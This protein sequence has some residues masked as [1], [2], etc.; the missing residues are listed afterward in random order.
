MPRRSAQ[1]IAADR[2]A[3]VIQRSENPLLY[4]AQWREVQ[5]MAFADRHRQRETRV[6]C[7]ARHVR[8]GT[9]VHY[10]VPGQSARAA[11]WTVQGEE[12]LHLSAAVSA[13]FCAFSEALHSAAP[14]ELNLIPKTLLDP[15]GAR[16]RFVHQG[17]VFFLRVT[18]WEVTSEPTQTSL[19]LYGEARTEEA[20]GVLGAVQNSDSGQWTLQAV[21]AA[22]HLLWGRAVADTLEPVAK[23]G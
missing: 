18:P 2:Q 23:A 15:G 4:V 17:V 10:G 11:L 6:I 3:A 9:T 20:R 8:G 19:V 13:C 21:R 22:Q 1:A 7:A 16:L 14:T 5:L 12:R